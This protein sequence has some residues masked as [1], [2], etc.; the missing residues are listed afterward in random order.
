MLKQG[1]ICPKLSA[2]SVHLAEGRDCS[3]P[4]RRL[5]DYL[6]FP[7]QLVGVVGCCELGLITLLQDRTERLSDGGACLTLSG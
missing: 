3:I 1:I 5:L 2:K 6:T 4:G 7:E